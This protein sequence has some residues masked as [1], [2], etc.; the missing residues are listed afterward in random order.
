MSTQW[1]RESAAK[2]VQRLHRGRRGRLDA[3]AVKK[4]SGRLAVQKQKEDAPSAKYAT[5]SPLVARSA[6]PES[7]NIFGLWR[8]KPDAEEDIGTGAAPQ[9]ISSDDDDDLRAD[10][11][12]ARP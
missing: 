6:K 9:P 11:P 12:A 8:R 5:H 4:Q 1:K 3:L 7:Q 10:P 2:M